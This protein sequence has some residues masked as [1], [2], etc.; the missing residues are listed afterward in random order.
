MSVIARRPQRQFTQAPAGTYHAV[1]VDVQNL[2]LQPSA[3]GQKHKVRL[4]WQIATVDET[5]NRRYELAR[6][7]T[8]S[9]HERAALRQDLERWRGRKFTDAELDTGFDLER[10]IGV[11]CQILAT[12]DL[13]DDGTTYANVS[14]VMPPP[15]GVPKLFPLDFTRLKDRHPRNSS[16]PP[17][18]EV[19]NDVPF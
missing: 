14:S 11:N 12:H 4:V 16:A 1:C 5:H 8:L 9:L 2:G 6:L 7:Y 15:P 13:G 3:W 10:L 19:A 18:Q 17:A